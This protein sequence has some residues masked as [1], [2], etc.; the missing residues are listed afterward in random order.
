MSP[1]VMVLI[2]SLSCSFSRCRSP[3]LVCAA[4]SF[5][6]SSL[7]WVS[8]R[9][10]AAGEMDLASPLLGM[11]MVRG[12]SGSAPPAEE[13]PPLDSPL[14]AV[15]RGSTVLGGRGEGCKEAMPAMLRPVR[16]G[17]P[18][19]GRDRRREGAVNAR[20]KCFERT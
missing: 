1:N 14:A 18:A 11:P 13:P 12:V 20:V 10:A 15:R 4:T 6:I 9:L 2:W 19:A 7:F 3:I 8:S 16:V 5:S 17:V